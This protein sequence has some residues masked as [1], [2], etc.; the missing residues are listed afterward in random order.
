MLPRM[1]R[2]DV[3]EVV[4]RHGLDRAWAP[5]GM[6]TGV[7]MVHVRRVARPDLVLAGQNLLTVPAE[8]AVRAHYRDFH[9]SPRECIMGN[10]AKTWGNANPKYCIS[11]SMKPALPELC[12]YILCI[13][14]QNKYKLH[15]HLFQ[16]EYNLIYHWLNLY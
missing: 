2:A 10:F 7:S 14:F 5:T 1:I 3:F 16:Y 6:K 15:N 4:R 11:K 8:L 13:L 9:R 12:D